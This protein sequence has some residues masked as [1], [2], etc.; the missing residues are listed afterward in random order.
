MGYVW[1]SWV[2]HVKC[3]CRSEGA[4]TSDTRRIRRRSISMTPEIGDDIVR[5]I[6][7]STLVRQ[8]IFKHG[9]CSS[10]L[11]QDPVA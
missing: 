8:F 11:L 4:S 6:L 1:A 2:F 9:D 7:S 5:L 10:K 3:D